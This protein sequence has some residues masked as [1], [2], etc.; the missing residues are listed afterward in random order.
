MFGRLQAL[1]CRQHPRVELVAVEDRDAERARAVGREL[2]VPAYDDVAALLRE[3]DFD[4][5]IVAT[6]EHVR[7]E[8]AELCA[9][10]G[11]HML[12]E[13]PLAPTVEECEAIVRAVRAA[14]V[15]A[16]VDF[17]LRFDSRYAALKEAIDAGRL[18]EI[19]SVAAKRN[20]TIVGARHYGRW[21]DLLL[22]TG[23]H[24]IDLL[25]WYAGPVERVSAEATFHHSPYPGIET[26]VFA[27]FRFK[28]GAIGLL[29]TS[30]ARPEG[31]P[32]RLDAR[33]EVVGTAGAG[34]VDLASHGLRLTEHGATFF[35]DFTYW[36]VSRGQVG[37]TLRAALDHFVGCVLDGVPP[38]ATMEDG[39]EAVRLAL[40]IK[41]AAARGTSVAVLEEGAQ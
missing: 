17:S 12:L 26:A 7:R 14:G 18:G 38:L 35:P 10:A 4:A 32:D 25:R 19:I 16:M 23:I 6:P 34:T 8:I 1:A 20:G 31:V 22:S 24:E 2:E 3:Q 9:A 29:E 27:T 41:E 30:W 33:C 11:R 39:R 40:A 36:P 37:G 28:S 15:V 5:V 21:T 13:K